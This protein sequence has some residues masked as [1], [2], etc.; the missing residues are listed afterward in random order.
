M[1]F[2][3]IKTALILSIAFLVSG[4]KEDPQRHLNLGKWY[5]QKGLVEEAILEFK[6]V[7]RLYPEPHKN[8]AREDYQA[9]SKAHYN[10]SLMYTKKGWWDYALKEAEI[11]FQM[12]PTKDHY[13]LVSLIKQRAELEESGS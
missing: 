6:E 4:C 12:L 7:T 1:K 9:L 3:F 8:L 2:S 13:D 5:A 10:L 11:C